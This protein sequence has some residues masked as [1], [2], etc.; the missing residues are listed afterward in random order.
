M[1]SSA[2]LRNL[3]GFILAI[4]TIADLVGSRVSMGHMR[5]GTA[6]PAIT[7]HLTGASRG[8]THAGADGFIT[9]EIQLDIWSAD[10]DTTTHDELELITDQLLE[11]HGFSGAIGAEPV[12]LVEVTNDLYLYEPEPGLHH[13]I[14]E[15]AIHHQE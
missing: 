5:Q 3:R 2:I 13:R 14:L 15:L 8:L 10:P 1:T 4:G 7:F 12:D 11:L 6:L 9:T